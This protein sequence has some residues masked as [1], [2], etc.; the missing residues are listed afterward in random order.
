MDPSFK[1]IYANGSNWI[2]LDS[3]AQIQLEHLWSKGINGTI[4][5]EKFPAPVFVNLD[6]MTMYYT[7][8][9]SDTYTYE[10]ARVF[11]TVP[12]M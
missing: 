10:I 3:S 1:W 8:Y 7:D 12:T 4:T 2:E 9:F 5:S 6:M 11:I